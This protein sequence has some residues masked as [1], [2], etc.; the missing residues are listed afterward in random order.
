VSRA[1]RELSGLGY[2][3]DIA[4]AARLD[5]YPVLAHFANRRVTA[6]PATPVPGTVL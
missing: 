2:K 1:G 3:D 6:M 4:D 5:G